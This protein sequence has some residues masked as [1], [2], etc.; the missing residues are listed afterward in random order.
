MSKTGSRGIATFAF[1]W[2]S[3]W[4][5]A[6]P[7][8]LSLLCMSPALWAQRDVRAPLIKISARAKAPGFQLTAESGGKVKLSDYQGKVIL[9]N[10]WATDCGGCVLEIPRLI[11]VQRDLQHGDFTV[12]GVD[13]DMPYGG[14]KSADDAWKRVRPFTVAHG[15]NYPV[16]MGT[17]AIEKL[18]GINAYP[19]SF[20][21]DKSGH[22]AAKY[23]GI[24]SKDDVEANVRTLSAK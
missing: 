9:L 19:A 3:K 12:V 13:M 1:L 22:I 6:F 2:S 24:V 21:I 14:V 10:F 11:D 18:Y 8:T 7:L 4:K 15:M 16:L 20:L 23:V 17:S 5:I